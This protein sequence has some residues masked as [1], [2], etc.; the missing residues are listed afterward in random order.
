MQNAYQCAAT[1]QKK[2]GPGWEHLAGTAQA[3]KIFVVFV[4]RIA[5]LHGEQTTKLAT[6]SGWPHRMKT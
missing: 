5:Q 4:R 6:V 1:G 2:Q 3:E